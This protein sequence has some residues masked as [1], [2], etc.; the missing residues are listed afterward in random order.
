MVGTNLKIKSNIKK[1]N[2]LQTPRKFYMI[3]T[4]NQVSTPLL[5]WK[6]KTEGVLLHQKRM[7]F[8]G[9]QKKRRHVGI[10]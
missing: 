1:E 6:K 5:I 4:Q 3:R 9:S 10:Q 2:V 8:L 7:M